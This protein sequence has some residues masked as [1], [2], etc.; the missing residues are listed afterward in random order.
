MM[1]IHRLVES[2]RLKL[3]KNKRKEAH[4]LK[5]GVF[6]TSLALCIPWL[7]TLCTLFLFLYYEKR[8]V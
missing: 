4:I 2:P 8:E 3:S 7:G 6:G 5:L 1:R